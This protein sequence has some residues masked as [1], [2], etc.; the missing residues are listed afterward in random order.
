MSNPTEVLAPLSHR[1]SHLPA[2]PQPRPAFG[3]SAAPPDEPSVLWTLAVRYNRLLVLGGV[4]SLLVAWVAGWLFARPLWQAEAVLVYQPVQFTPE[5]QIAY[6]GAPSVGTLAGWMKE[7]RFLDGVLQEGGL[8]LSPTAFADQYLKVD[9]PIGT[10]NV[11][12][13]L[14]W[15]DSTAARQLL[16]LLLE[17]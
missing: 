6:A 14:K 7:P 15:T 11:S 13:V 5:Q 3:F 17:R 12:V 16:D 8:R 2:I 10:E 4:A 9:Q 1:H